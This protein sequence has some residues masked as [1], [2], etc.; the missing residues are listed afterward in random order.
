MNIRLRK[1]KQNRL[2]GMN[3][4][5]AALAAGYSVNVAGRKTHRLEKG[6]K[7]AIQDALE[8][9]GLTDKFQAEKLAEITRAT[10]VISCNVFV[11]RDGEMKKADGK[12]L[13]FV[14]VPDYPVQ[15]KALEHI[16]DLKRQKGPTSIQIGGVSTGQLNITMITPPER[17]D[18]GNNIKAISV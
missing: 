5:N 18:N 17:M 13:D 1:Y 14:E 7:G 10:K 16:A 11:D 6:P 12:S 9:A 3:Q 2:R 4:K 15:L 8:Q